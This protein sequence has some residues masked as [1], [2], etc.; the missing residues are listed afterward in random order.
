MFPENSIKEY[1]EIKAKTRT[2]SRA[3]IS[4]EKAQKRRT[5]RKFYIRMI[6]DSPYTLNGIFA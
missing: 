6:R 4:L 1:A 3:P 2:F 5:I